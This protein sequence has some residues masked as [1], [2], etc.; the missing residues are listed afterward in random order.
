[1]DVFDLQ[2]YSLVPNVNL[3]NSYKVEAVCDDMNFLS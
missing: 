1:M 3:S 2:H